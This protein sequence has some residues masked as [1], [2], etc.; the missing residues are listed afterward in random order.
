[1][2]DGLSWIVT[3]PTQVTVSVKCTAQLIWMSAACRH[4]L[5]VGNL[6]CQLVIKF[7]ERRDICSSF[8]T[9][10]TTCCRWRICGRSA[11]HRLRL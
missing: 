7:T 9:T 5:S 10:S 3:R 6:C 8:M 1:M 4:M 2:V 11:K